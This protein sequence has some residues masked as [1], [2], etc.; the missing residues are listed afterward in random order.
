[1]NSEMR[2]RIEARRFPEMRWAFPCIV[3][4]SLV[5][6]GVSAQAACPS[7]TID[8]NFASSKAVFSGRAISQKVVPAAHQASPT[9]GTTARETETTFEVDKIWKGELSRVF[10]VRTCGW[11]DGV[12]AVTCSESMTFR[13]GS[14]YVVF[15]R[16]T[17]LTPTSCGLHNEDETRKFL[18]QKAGRSPR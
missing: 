14:Q 5:L 4:G 6:S 17:P 18:S 1:M 16:G 12:E 11:T 13:V 9:S 15:A 7:T 3:F 2:S 10:R 8:Q